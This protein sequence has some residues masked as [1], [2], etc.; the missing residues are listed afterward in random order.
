MIKTKKMM[1]ILGLLTITVILIGVI[2]ILSQPP[3]YVDT[4][5]I[6][7]E[8]MEDITANDINS[9][10]KESE[11]TPIAITEPDPIESADN[12]D[13]IALTQEADKPEP[14]EL[15]DTAPQEENSDSVTPEDVIAHEEADP[16]LKDPTK[17]PDVTTPPVTGKAPEEPK[18]G[19]TNEKGEVYVPGFG[20]AVPSTSVGEV[21]TSDGDWNKIIGY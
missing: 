9:A 3:K 5:T 12:T 1:T 20:W 6:S 10:E 13:E 4:S 14:P 19:S 11:I 21:S 16:A 8:I 15:P 17:K 18:G 2:F 7:D